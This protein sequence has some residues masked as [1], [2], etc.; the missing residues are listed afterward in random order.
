MQRTLQDAEMSLLH[1]HETNRHDNVSI[2]A[3]PTIA[4]YTEFMIIDQN[5]DFVTTITSGELRPV[6][7]I[8]NK[9]NTICVCQDSVN[10]E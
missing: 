7:Q 1:V 3:P 10:V 9:N 6:F 5:A 8:K 4:L 2:P